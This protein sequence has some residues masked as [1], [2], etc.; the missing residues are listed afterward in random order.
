MTITINDLPRFLAA[1]DRMRVGVSGVYIFTG[2]VA[3][4]WTVAL[5]APTSPRRKEAAFYFVKN[6]GTA[7]LTLNASSPNN[8]YDGSSSSSIAIAPGGGVTLLW[9]G[10]NYAVMSTMGRTFADS[11]G[12]PGAQTAVTRVGRCSIA[13]A[14]LS[15]LQ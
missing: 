3:S 10:T 4:S 11:S 13:A 7:I 5:G 9:D 12:T 15:G 1:G 6:E 2:T 8:F 14:G